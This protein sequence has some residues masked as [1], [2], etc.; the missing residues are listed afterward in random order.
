MPGAATPGIDG[1]AYFFAA[2]A[3]Q[4]PQAF[5]APHAP[6]APQTFFLAAQ[7]PQAAMVAPHAPQ[8]P[9]D[10]TAG[11]TPATAAA[12]PPLTTIMASAFL[13]LLF[14]DFS[15]GVGPKPVGTSAN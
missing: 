9:Q 7:A 12:R 5:T 3:P 15:S 2:Q 14:I 4:A 6:Q 1:S 13:D 10:A 11:V 8:A